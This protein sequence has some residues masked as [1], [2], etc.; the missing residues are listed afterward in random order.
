MAMA[1]RDLI[2]SERTIEVFLPAI[3]LVSVLSDSPLPAEDGHG[4]R[5]SVI[6]AYLH[7]TSSKD[8]TAIEEKYGLQLFKTFATAKTRVYR[9]PPTRSLTQTLCDLG[10]EG[11]VRYAEIDQDVTG[12]EEHRK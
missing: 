10:K 11:A 1:L 9:L 8:I 3:V 7:E 12:K 2:D 6:V 4:N 5:A